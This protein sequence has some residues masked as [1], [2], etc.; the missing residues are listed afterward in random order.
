MDNHYHLIIETPEGNLSKGMR[1]LGGVFTQTFNRRH[2]RVGHLFQGR[3]KAILVEKDS[4]L[5]ELCRYVV[6]NPVRAGME[7]TVEDWPWSSYPATV[8]QALAHP[9]LSTDWILGQ[10]CLERDKARTKYSRFVADGVGQD[11]VWGDLKGQ[12]LL[13][14]EN[15]TTQFID[16][17]KNKSNITEIPRK[18]RLI[19]RPSLSDLFDK[20]ERGNKASRNGRIVEAVDVHGYAQ[21]EVAS[22]LDLHYS[23][24]S[25]VICKSVKNQD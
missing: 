6:L 13:G 12:V 20:I 3:F 24:I 9:S 23:T 5:L 10:F 16:V 25:Q 17:L 21:S 11:T 2:N 22:E 19:D 8:G 1:Q 15:F 4:Y 18:Q 7:K 14:R